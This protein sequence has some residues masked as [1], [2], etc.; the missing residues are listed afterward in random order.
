M[1]PY[2]FQVLAQMLELHKEARFPP[3]IGIFFHFY[4]LPL[5][6]AKRQH[7]RFGQAFDCLLS[8]RQCIDGGAGQI[9]PVLAVAQQRLIPSKANDEWG[10]EL[11]QAVVRH[12]KQSVSTFIM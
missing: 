12:V 4:S 8:A 5:F 2:V 7:P 3:S 1:F 9:A 10:I 6:A 11:L